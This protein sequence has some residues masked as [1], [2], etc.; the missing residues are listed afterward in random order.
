MLGEAV[1]DV[2]VRADGVRRAY[3][4]GSA[5]N[6]AVALA[7]LGREVWLGSCWADDEPGRALAGHLAAEG[8]RLATDPMT[9]P[10]TSTA[11]ARV[12]AA[13]V[14]DYDLDVHWALG[15]LVVPQAPPS[16]VGCGSF[17]AVLDPLGGVV[18]EALGRWPEAVRFF[19]VNVRGVVTGAGPGVRARVEDLFGRCDLVKVSDEDL[20]VLWPGVPEGDVLALAFGAGVR[21]VLLSRGAEGASWCTASGRVDAEAVR[22]RVADTVGAG[23]TLGAAAL[24]RLW[25]LGVLR[26]DALAD[27][28]GSTARD[29]L[30]YAAAAAAV[31]VSR[32]G[33]N[34]PRADEVRPPV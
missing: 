17:A 9:V 1:Y 14:P 34:P 28:D 23:D 18:D 27:L 3:P 33:A 30:R 22:A 13:G 11:L 5:A 24:H 10:R 2:T 15:P 19:D 7:R 31:T 8:V 6:Q 16:L 29:V 32:V 25:D 26:R 21:A 20:S 4:G 12:D